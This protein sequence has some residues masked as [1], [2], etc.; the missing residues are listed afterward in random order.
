MT[1]GNEDPLM[2]SEAS[3]PVNTCEILDGES[4]LI[5]L[6]DSLEDDVLGILVDLQ[7]LLMEVVLSIGA[8]DVWDLETVDQGLDLAPVDILGL[9]QDGDVKGSFGS[10]G[11]SCLSRAQKSTHG[12]QSAC[13]HS[14]ILFIQRFST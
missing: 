2:S 12:E 10:L 11:S 8:V 7:G 5:V 9:I 6:W 1:G 4:D 3:A 14:L 13:N